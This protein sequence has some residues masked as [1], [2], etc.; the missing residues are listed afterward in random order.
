MGNATIT[1]V[2]ARIMIKSGYSGGAVNVESVDWIK[3]I[4]L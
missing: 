1:C 2:E 3:L 4:F